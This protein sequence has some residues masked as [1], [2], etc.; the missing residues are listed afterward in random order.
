MATRTSSSPGAGTGRS[1]RTRRPSAAYP[2]ARMS[3]RMPRSPPTG[4]P[5]PVDG[6]LALLPV[7]AS[8]PIDLRSLLDPTHSA[9]LT[10]ECQEAIIGERAVLPALVE[11]VRAS[12]LRRN[13][14]TLAARARAA[15]V[16]VVH[17]LALRRP[18]SG[19][20]AG[21]CQPP[22]PRAPGDAPPPGGAPAP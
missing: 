6:A 19:G 13:L 20:S 4:Q 18:D 14:G 5:P 8:M 2:A 15:G 16:P 7:S 17:N 1:S 12:G 9:L 3:I 10:M 21:E 11:A 22:P